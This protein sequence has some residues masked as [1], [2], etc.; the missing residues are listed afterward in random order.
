MAKVSIVVPVYNGEKYLNQT[1]DSVLSQTWRDFEVIVVDDG[2]TDG[3]QKIVGQ[4]KDDR[5]KYFYK[6]NGG[7]S[8][9]R[10]Y[11]IESA[12]GE[13][14][15][16][17]DADDIW[18]S[19]KLERQLNFLKAHEDIGVVG[20]NFQYLNDN[21]EKTEIFNMRKLYPN[22]GFNLCNL[23][24]CSF[25]LPSSVLI[26][27]EVVDNAGV[28]DPKFD[29]AEDTEYFLR[30]LKKYSLGILDEVLLKY[31]VSNSSFS[32]GFRAYEIRDK[33][34]NHFF[35]NYLSD[36]RFNLDGVKKEAYHNLYFQHGKELLWNGM[37][38]EARGYFKKALKNKKT[39]AA[40]WFYLKS[41][42]KGFLMSLGV[43]KKTS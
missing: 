16:F 37:T 12:S 21:A 9:A 10:N 3:T 17:L 43:F 1:L 2:S 23:L 7:P 30:I 42:F 32:R 34:L 11:G 15:A 29:G 13:Y 39:A 35:L 28:F 40:V 18:E 8:S 25:L 14:I 31:R 4:Y 26:R 27:K 22:D 5:L 41:Y 6:E 19:E 24:A 20:C 33:V 38:P 36:E